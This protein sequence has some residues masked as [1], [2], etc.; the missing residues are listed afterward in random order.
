MTEDQFWRTIINGL[1]LEKD[2]VGDPVFMSEEKE[3]EEPDPEVELA[4]QDASILRFKLD[5]YIISALETNRAF[6]MQG[7][8][9][10]ENGGV[11]KIKDAIKLIER[12][13]KR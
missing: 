10:M 11:M 6:L 12:R 7:K 13:K 4:E 1:Q 2:L 5:L 8:S 9:Q 3:E